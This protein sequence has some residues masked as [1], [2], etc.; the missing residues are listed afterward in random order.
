MH[1]RHLEWSSRDG[2]NAVDA[3]E[4]RTRVRSLET[5]LLRST[6][7]GAREEGHSQPFFVRQ[8][9]ADDP[10][11]LSLVAGTGTRPG[12]SNRIHENSRATRMPA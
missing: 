7:G 5:R 2:R 1:P 11:L 10:R 12:P 3:V 6:A 4:Q 9:P 8:P